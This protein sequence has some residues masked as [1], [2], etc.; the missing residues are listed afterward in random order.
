MNAKG[1]AKE[2]SRGYEKATTI[3]NHP[4]FEKWQ[5]DSKNGELNVFVGK[6][7]LLTVEGDDIADTKV[8]HEFV[9]QMDLGKL[10]ALK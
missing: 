6:R 8:L 3:A 2:S 10:A 9:G 7:F 5:K 1:Y 4:G